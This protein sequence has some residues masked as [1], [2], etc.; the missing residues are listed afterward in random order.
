MASPA[1]HQKSVKLLASEFRAREQPRP[2]FLLGAGASITSGVPLAADLVRRIGRFG[3]AAFVLGNPNAF[4]SVT[5]TDGQNYL[6]T[7]NWFRRDALAECF[8]A[9][10]QE[11]LRPDSRRRQFFEQNTRHTKISE[12]YH[13]LARMMT[14]GL[15]RTVLT[16]NFDDLLPESLRENRLNFREIVEVNKTPGDLCRFHSHHRC[17]IVWMHGRWEYYT[18][19]NLTEEVQKLDGELSH[20]LWGVL[21]EAP[22]IVVG[23]RGA[24]PSISKHLLL[25]GAP[26]AGNFRHGIFWCCRNP[27]D[28]HPQ[29][30]DLAKLLKSNFRQ[31]LIQ[32]FDSLMLDLDR[33]LTTEQF[34]LDS[35][36]AEPPASWDSRQMLEASVDDIDTA[37]A[38]STLTSYAKLL[39]LPPFQPEKLQDALIDRGLVIRVDEKLVPTHA[40]ILLFGKNPQRLAPHAIV[41]FTTRKKAQ[42]I[43]QGNLIKQLRDI[44]TALSG[45]DVNPQLRI[46]NQEGLEDRAAYAPRAVNELVANLLVHRDYEVG[47]MGTVDHEPGNGIVFTNPGGLFGEAAQRIHIAADGHFNPVRGASAARN[48]IIADILCGIEEIQKLGSGLADVQNLME[49]HGGKTE[50]AVSGQSPFPRFAA[51]LLQAQQAAETASVATRR[52]ETELFTTNLLPFRNLPEFLYRIPLR[53]PAAKKAIF[54][55][56]EWGNLPVCVT[57]PGYL[58][59]FTN[60]EQTPEFAQRNGIIEMQEEIRFKDA[61]KDEVRRRELVWLLG[62]HWRRHLAQFEEQGLVVVGKEKRAYFGLT[63]AKSL[64]VNYTTLLGRRARRE[65]VKVRGEKEDQHENEG[66]YYQVVQMSGELAVQIKPTYVFTG[67]D[68]ITPLPPRF[69]TRKATRRFKFDRNKMV[70]DDL[71]FWAR[72]LGRESESVNL[73]GGWREDLILDMRYLAVELPPPKEVEA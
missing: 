71:M 6:R 2:I 31:V 34:F 65:V 35:S 16:T 14:R 3:H 19:C 45:P 55:A 29:V 49:Q 20:R 13:A 8:P 25:E 70:G 10:V 24:E 26:H 46:K 48:A 68:G 43:F 53:D 11:V 59:Q 66:F 15:S 69:Q 22:L 54:E 18:D 7:F 36:A 39:G 37:T 67:K 5:E 4:P 9:A 73:G 58:L 63:T 51:T 40:C 38:I 27:D 52:T 23:Y 56:D 32:D 12:G 41:S 61:M 44:R 21:A 60:F 50:F 72:Y 64:M 30:Q 47:E 57:A 28:F 33:E 42:V 1:E 62:A 17:Q